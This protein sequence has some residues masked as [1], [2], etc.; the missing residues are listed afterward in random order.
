M[1]TFFLWSDWTQGSPLSCVIFSVMCTSLFWRHIY[2]YCDFC[3]SSMFPFQCSTLHFLKFFQVEIC[4]R[5]G[6]SD[7]SMPQEHNASIPALS[8]TQKR[9]N[10]SVQLSFTPRG[11]Q[12]SVTS[13][14]FYFMQQMDWINYEQNVYTSVQLKS[15]QKDFLYYLWNT[16]C[17]NLRNWGDD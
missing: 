3:R 4:L 10:Y 11:S 14:A 8:E 12:F 13:E 2:F 5:E 15:N 7:R 16:Y 9:K 17:D 6:V 1:P